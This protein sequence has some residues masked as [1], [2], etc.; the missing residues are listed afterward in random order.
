M[1]SPFWLKQVLLFRVVV[2]LGKPEDQPEVM[3][4]ALGH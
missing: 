2:S 1:P 3:E 4:G